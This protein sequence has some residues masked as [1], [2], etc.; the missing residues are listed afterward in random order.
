[1]G[2]LRDRMHDELVLRGLRPTTV[3]NYLLCAKVFVRHYRRPPEDMGRDEVR[4]FLLHLV[5]I[6]RSP[7]TVRV[8]RAALA[9]L[10]ADV[11]G[12]P[13]VPNGLPAPKVRPKLPDVPSREEVDRILAAMTD[14]FDTAFFLTLYGAGLRLGE[15]CRLQVGDVDAAQMLLRVHDGK[16]G[17]DRLVMLDPVVLDALRAYWRA[18]RPPGPW[19]FPAARSFRGPDLPRFA[20]RPVL[21]DTMRE[22]FLAACARARLG[23]RLRVHS[24]RHAF[25]THLLEDGVGLRRLQT[26]LGHA[27]V[28]T[29]TRY[30]LVRT[31]QIRR[32]PS[33]LARKHRTAGP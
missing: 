20:D 26:L 30:T 27:D 19:L 9:F 23:R 32:T 17:K 6:G 5:Q 24:L 15:A 14:P 22:R 28:R 7:A 31:D 4:D 29:T 16:G 8:Y 13:E 33:P 1:M 18:Q 10:Y 12:R 2:Q 3:L 21:G 25:A 11:L